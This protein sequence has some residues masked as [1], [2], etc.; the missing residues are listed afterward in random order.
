MLSG[1]QSKMHEARVVDAH[2]NRDQGA[3]MTGAPENHHKEAE[4][5]SVSPQYAG[6]NDEEPQVH[7][8]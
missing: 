1:D 2:Q 7:Q 6:G 4:I 5:N 8:P 3:D